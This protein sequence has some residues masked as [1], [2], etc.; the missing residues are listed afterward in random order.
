MKTRA[1]ILAGGEGTRL[2]VL[3]AK[4]TKPAVPFAGKYRMI[5]FP[6]SN[7]VN[8]NIYDVMIIAQY[9][10]QSL[11]EH[12]GSGGPWDLN[13]DFTGGVRIFTP[14]KSR[15]SGWF[16]GTADAVQQNF[17]FI[18]RSEPDLV[19]ILSG[20]HVYAMDYSK[21]IEYHFDHHADLTM[22]TIRVPIEEASRYGIVDV[23]PDM[24][25]TSFIEKPVHPPSNLVNMGVYLF[26][27]RVL[28]E[29]LW[30]DNQRKE[31]SHDFGKDIL[32]SMVKNGARVF[33]FPYDGYWVDVGTV[34][35]YWKAHMD[36]LKSPT[37]FDLYDRSWIIHTRTEERP[38]VRVD[39]GATIE[40]SMICD[41]C[42]IE[43]GAKVIRSI[44]SP[45]VHI[46]AG[47]EVIESVVL[48]DADINYGASVTR[49]ILDKH[50]K[51]RE[52]SIMGEICEGEIKISMAGKHAII[53][54]NTIVRGGASIGP[55]VIAEDYHSTLIEAG[56]YIQTRRLP[57]E[58]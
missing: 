5:D 20:D 6:L 19:L 50:C 29:A 57:Y 47:A 40:D 18:K 52:N 58:I 48:T 27:R 32:P 7:C 46:H 44:L 54:P 9:R 53:P 55:D 1:V 43:A 14:Y 36:L 24:S 2:G 3:T 33:A 26:D 17:L 23:A 31:S 10:P 8:S 34:E 13:R 28:D 51:I 11:I 37:P 45:G 4:R 22:A 16:I 15:A 41:G 30:Q 25:V 56:Q 35:S 39:R 38:P 21:M 12:I 42:I 49:S